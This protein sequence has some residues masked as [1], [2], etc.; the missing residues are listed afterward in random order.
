MQAKLAKRLLVVALIEVGYS[1]LFG[2]DIWML[3]LFDL[4]GALWI[5]ALWRPKQ[6][7][8]IA[9]YWLKALI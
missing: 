4:F 7:K 8:R 9:H 2:F 5:L 1:I 3:V 6:A